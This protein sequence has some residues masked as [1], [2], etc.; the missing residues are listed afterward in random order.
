MELNGIT[1]LITNQAINK[2]LELI[3]PKLITLIIFVIFLICKKRLNIPIINIKKEDYKVVLGIFIS[4]LLANI[5]FH[6]ESFI[7]SKMVNNFSKMVNN[8]LFN[9]CLFTI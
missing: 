4:C 8:H 9:N 3:L 6:F 2:N 1:S 5:F 7:F